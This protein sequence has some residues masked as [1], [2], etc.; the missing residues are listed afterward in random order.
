MRHVRAY[1]C[2][3]S[4]ARPTPQGAA[5]ERECTATVTSSATTYILHE[6]CFP[7]FR[8]S[9]SKSGSVQSTS[10]L[11]AEAGPAADAEAEP[12]ADLTRQPFSA[13]NFSRTFKNFVWCTDGSFYT[14]MCE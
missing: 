1:T 4:S 13:I 3:P 9:P 12:D 8:V 7:E 2:S 10:E 5:A 6:G 11:E 14:T